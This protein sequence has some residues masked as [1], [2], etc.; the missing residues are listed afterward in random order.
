MFQLFSTTYSSILF[1][2]LLYLYHPNATACAIAKAGVV[3]LSNWVW[4]LPV[5][6]SVWF[7]SAVVAV[8]PS[9]NLISVAV[10]VTATSSLILGLVSLLLVNVCVELSNT[11]EDALLN[12]SR[13]YSQWTIKILIYDFAIIALSLTVTCYISCKP[14]TNV[15]PVTFT[16]KI[17]LNYHQL[18]VVVDEPS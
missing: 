16:G 13:F 12:V 11:I 5:T 15:V 18:S 9:V 6:P 10:A 17:Y 7:N 1:S 2:L 4:I 8:T 3:L 14:P